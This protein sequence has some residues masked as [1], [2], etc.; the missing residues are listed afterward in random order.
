MP[1]TGPLSSWMLCGLALSGVG[2]VGCGSDCDDTTRL[3]GDWTVDSRVSA[4]TWQVS[5]FDT[6]ASDD[7]T[8]DAAAIDQADLLAQLLVNGT[9]TWSI[10]R[11]GASDDYT[12]RVDGQEF[13]ARLV[14]KKGACNAF[15]VDFT[16]TWAGDEGSSHNFTFD[17]QL[18][19][20]G[21][22]LTAAWQYS[23]N[24]SWEDRAATGTVAIP[25]G[26]FS[27]TRASADSG[28]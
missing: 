20:L 2:L 26:V 15:D 23:D 16:G 3:D 27:A 21:D 19:F 17:G 24:F 6:T 1:S 25:T 28:G 5:G 12:L 7:T 8:A 11:S 18:T 14:P 9:K 10:A 4:E 22:E 13:D